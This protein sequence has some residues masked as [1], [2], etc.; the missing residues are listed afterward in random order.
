[1]MCIED[2]ARVFVAFSLATAVEGTAHAKPR[3]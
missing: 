2:F 1:L 3:S